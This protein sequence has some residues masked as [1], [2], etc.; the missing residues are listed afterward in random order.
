MLPLLCQRNQARSLT[1]LVGVQHPNL[2]AAVIAQVG[3][4]DLLRYPLFTI[5]ALSCLLLTFCAL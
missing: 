5:G 4:M 3:V 2:Y 1:E